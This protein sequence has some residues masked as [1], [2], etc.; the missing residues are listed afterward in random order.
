MVKTYLDIAHHMEGLPVFFG[1]D[2]K[3]G[4]FVSRFSPLLFALI[5]LFKKNNSLYVLAIIITI[6]T[7][8]S[9]ERTSFLMFM[10][11]LIL[12][13]FFSKIEFKIKILTTSLFFIFSWHYSIF[14]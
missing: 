4:G 3:L 13:F 10:I 9:G 12:L 11:Y 8:L 6:L 2:I 7:I 5:F 1:D 14:K